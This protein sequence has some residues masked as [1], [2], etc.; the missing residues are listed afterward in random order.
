MK[1]AFISLPNTLN[2]V[3]FITNALEVY[4]NVLVAASNLIYTGF[5]GPPDIFAPVVSAGVV[6][7][8]ARTF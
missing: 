5:C 3:S 4:F 2:I 8:I 1:V 7:S 6:N